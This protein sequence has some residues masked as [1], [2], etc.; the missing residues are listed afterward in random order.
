MDNPQYD[1]AISFLSK[2]EPIAAAIHHK[3]TEGLKVFFFLRSQEDLAGT[4][5]LESMRKPFFD[6]SRVMVVLYREP[7]V[8]HRG[9][10]LR[11]VQS[12][13]PALS[14]GGRDCFLLFWTGRALS[15]FG[16]LNTMFAS[17]FLTSD[18][19][20]RSGPSRL[21]FRRTEENIRRSPRRSE[22]RYSKLRSCFDKTNRE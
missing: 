13:K 2:D 19:N 11:K 6:E 22:R 10:E 3:L 1:V 21:V 18:Q 8:R 16:C 15:L 20:R 14:T 5:G 17:I 9:H 7:W 4:D 12:K